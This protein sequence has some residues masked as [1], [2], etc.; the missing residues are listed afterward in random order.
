[1]L[2]DAVSRNLLASQEIPVGIFTA[3]LGVPFFLS[4]LS[5]E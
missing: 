2:A 1:M 5:K 4:Q 3:L